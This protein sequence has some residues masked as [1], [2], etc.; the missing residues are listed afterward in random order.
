MLSGGL[1]REEGEGGKE[2]RREEEKSRSEG[3]GTRGGKEGRKI[4]SDEEV[5][6]Q[7]WLRY[8]LN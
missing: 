8:K 1:E 2:G 5:V 3:K 7:N 4:N 6:N